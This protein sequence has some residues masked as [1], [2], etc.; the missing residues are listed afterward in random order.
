MTTISLPENKYNNI[1]AFEKSFNNPTSRSVLFSGRENK[2]NISVFLESHYITI[3]MFIV[4][5]QL[6]SL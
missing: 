5:S 3:V 6:M 4:K 1:Y 2:Y